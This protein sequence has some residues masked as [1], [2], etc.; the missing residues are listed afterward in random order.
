MW[1]YNVVSLKM[2]TDCLADRLIE[3][4]GFYSCSGVPPAALAHFFLQFHARSA[5]GLILL[6]NDFLRP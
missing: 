6:A 4:T 1:L 3:Y 5:L 2:N